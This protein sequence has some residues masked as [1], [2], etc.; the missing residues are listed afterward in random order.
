MLKTQKMYKV[1]HLCDNPGF[2]YVLEIRGEEDAQKEEILI[3]HLMCKADCIRCRL[4]DV[5]YK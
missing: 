1:L 2:D 5:L 4:I 3:F